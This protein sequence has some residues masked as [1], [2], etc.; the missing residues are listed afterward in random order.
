MPDRLSPETFT[1]QALH[2]IEP[3][4]GGVIPPVHL[5]TT[6]A[7]GADYALPSSQEY[8]RDDNPTYLPAE[9][10]LSALERGHEALLFSSGMAAATTAL[11]ALVAPGCHIVAPLAM[12]QG[13][14]LWLRDWCTRW[15]V[16]LSEVDLSSPEALVRAVQ[17]GRT[18]VVWA[19]TPANPT[20]D[21]VD[22]AS[23]AA[24]AHGAGARLIVD[25][26]LATP[27]HTQALTL[28]AD[29]VMHSATKFLNGHSDVLA[30]ALV[31]AGASEAWSQIRQLRHQQGAVPG[32]FEAWLLLR[33]M[34]T[35]FVRMA[36][37]SATA[38]ELARRLEQHPAVAQVLYPGLA[39]HPGHAVAAR[40]MA[41]GFGAMLSVLVRGGAAEAIAV[42]GRLQV[43]LR[44]TS[45][46]GVESLVEHRATVEGAGSRAPQNLLRLS[47]GIESVEDLWLDLDEALRR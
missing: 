38:A 33:G 30:G 34:R 35:L 47:I 7:R 45:L 31:A 39:G 20:C 1:A 22:I 44:A 26:T 2:C 9:R 4:H 25:S 28:G 27:V 18:R 41:N 19:E 36:R 21:I 24:I 17:P 5:A 37:A 12:Y 14:R 29:L 15:G 6:Y 23:A 32:P 42:A 3:T 40:Q 16:L 13:L 46:G 43:F 10:L 11:Q 8:T